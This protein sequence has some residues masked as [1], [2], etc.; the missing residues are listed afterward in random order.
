MRLLAAF[1][2][3]VVVALAPA[4]A[5]DTPG[6]KVHHKKAVYE[7]VRDGLEQAIVAKG[8]VVDYIGHFNTMLERTSEAAGS[9]SALGLK[10]PYRQAQYMQFCAAKLTHEAISANPHAIANCPYVLFVYEL[11]RQPGE[12]HVGYRLPVGGP[13]M[14]TKKI[15][16]QI[17]AL[18]EEIAL[19]AF[20]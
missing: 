20:K 5:A 15:N 17:E 8:Y 10:S 13:S 3:A 11:A 19:A 9:V 1:A 12:I 4:W 6:Y 7:D 14:V 18:M 2:A 16:T